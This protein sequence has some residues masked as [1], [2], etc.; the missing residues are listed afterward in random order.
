V[1]EGITYYL[2]KSK[3]G[4]MLTLSGKDHKKSF[5]SLCHGSEL[6]NILIIGINYEA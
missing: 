6:L 1:G 5:Q 2:T 4:N 3:P